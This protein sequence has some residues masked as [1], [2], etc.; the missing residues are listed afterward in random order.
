MTSAAESDA[1]SLSD[2]ITGN[3]IADGLQ[4]LGDALTDAAE[5]TREYRT[6]MASLEVSSEHAGYTAEQTAESYQRLYGV[7]ADDQTAA[8][9]TANL[10]AMQLEQDQ[11]NQM[12]SGAVGAWARYGD[13]I[14]IDGLAE[15][16]NET[17]RCGEVTGALADVLNWGSAE[18]ETFGVMLRENTEANQEWND[19]VTDASTAEDYFNLA[20][21]Q[22]ADDA[23]RANLILQMMAS[24]GLV[25]AGQQW[26]ANNQTLVDANQSMAEQ[27]DMLSELGDRAEPVLTALRDGFTDVLSGVLS[28]TDGLDTSGIADSIRDIGDAFGALLQ[29]GNVAPLAGLVGEMLQ[30]LQAGVAAGLPALIKSGADIINSLAQGAAQ[31]VPKFLVQALPMLMQFSGQLRQNAGQLIDAGLNLIME[32]GNGLIAGIPTL[33]QTV[34]TIVSNIAGIIN[35]NAPKLLMTAGTLIWNLAAGLIQSIPVLIQEAPKIVSA[36][37]DVITAFNWL[38]LGRQMITGL[39][40]GITNM[41]G[42]VKTAAVN[43]KNNVVS[44]LQNLP[45]TL[46]NLGTNAMN[47]IRTAFST[48]LSAARNVVSGGVS[49]IKN[50]FSSG[51]NGAKSVVSSVLTAIQ[52]KFTSVIN[53]AKNVV[54]NGINAIKGFFKF[55]W[56]L[57]KLKLPHI[58]ISGSFSLAPP[59]APKF[60]IKWYREGG[61]LE[62]PTIF[63][64]MGSTLLGGGEAG[65]EAVAPIDVLQDYVASAVERT[66]STSISSLAAAVQA[67]A[68]RPVYLQINGRTFAAVTAGDTDDAL[69][70]RQA[71][72]AR[73][74]CL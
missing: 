48:G 55:S 11:L 49:G 62:A 29:T 71:L 33:I 25:E 1:L 46:K 38:N 39:K 9:T 44:A 34:P 31:G 45:T 3:L 10:Q 36:V 15:S 51:L 4:A 69:G 8:T 23:E 53:G 63:G 66:I 26:E 14:P 40:N 12:I 7:L 59:R 42:G 5:S 22:C 47:G 43:V 24:Q 19:A 58:S 6:I 16:I 67:M 20:L 30:S 18:G 70:T 41:I 64:R 13:S 32:L 17:L 35:D 60:S 21:S 2:V 73:G 57:P 72:M 61:I 50:L 54:R 68:D 56:S 65:P 28:L 52:S 74:L 27:Q 37:V